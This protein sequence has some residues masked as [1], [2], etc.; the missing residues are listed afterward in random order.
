MLTSGE[1][2]SL[3]AAPEEGDVSRLA[4]ESKA[5]PYVGDEPE[6]AVLPE[7]GECVGEELEEVASF[8]DDDD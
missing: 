6:P 1:L 4:R 2:A 3:P 5:L 7:G 8:E